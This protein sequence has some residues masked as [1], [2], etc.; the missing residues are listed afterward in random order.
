M[1]RTDP[2]HSGA[3]SRW[4]HPPRQ[5]RSQRT[6]E[7]LLDATALLLEKNRFDDLRVPAI[8]KQ[9]KLSVGAFYARFKDR[10]AVLH[11]LHHQ[12]CE[13]TYQ[14]ADASLAPDRL[15]GANVADIVRM[16][17]G[18]MRDLM[19][20]KHG[21]LRAVFE[22]MRTDS[23]LHARQEA[24]RS[25]SARRVINLL[26]ARSDQIGHPDTERSAEFAVTLIYSVLRTRVLGYTDPTG[27]QSLSTE[28]VA[29]E[30][31]DAVLAYLGADPTPTKPEITWGNGGQRASSNA[32]AAG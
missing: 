27:A 22:Q 17:V 14:E 30:L 18:H 23:E 11:A 12:Y 21:F 6:L 1:T 26:I 29:E 25:Y 10:N 5:T 32:G 3:L 15:E 28:E 19:E 7:R 20:R 9:A 8:A 4:I 31:C 24:L 2:F 16:Y 13:A